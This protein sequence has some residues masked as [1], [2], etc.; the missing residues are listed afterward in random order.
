[1]MPDLLRLWRP[2]PRAVSLCRL[3]W[4]ILPVSVAPELPREICRL[5]VVESVAV[6]EA[7]GGA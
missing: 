4:V 7:F 6:L 3:A 2:S 1:M 5:F